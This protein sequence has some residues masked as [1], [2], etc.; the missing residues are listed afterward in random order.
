MAESAIKPFQET[1]QS[2]WED[3]NE[4][5]GFNSLVLAAGLSWRQ[6]MLLRAY[7]RYLRQGGTPYSQEY[8]EDTLRS[9]VDITGF[10]VK[11]FEARF[12][13]GRNGDIAA[14]AEARTAKCEDL[15]SR[16]A[17]ALDQVAGLDQDRI[18]R[19]YL[20]LIKATLRTNYFQREDNGT[21]DPSRTPTSPSSSTRRPSPTCPSRGRSSRSSSTHR[22]SRASTCA[23]APSPA[24]ACAGPTVATTS[25]PRSSVWSRRRWSRTP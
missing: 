13:P 2:V 23:S 25:A 12:D 17:R 5:D 11:L 18:L 14:D 10:L 9:N 24:V 21:G 19:S 7:A 4:S 1:V 22:G 20:T 6:A 8:I 15:E 16:I 3:R